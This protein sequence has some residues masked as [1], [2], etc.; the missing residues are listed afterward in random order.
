LLQ[1]NGLS[2][3]VRGVVTG[4][5]FPRSGGAMVVTYPFELK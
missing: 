5:H 1:R 4:L 3:C 2:K